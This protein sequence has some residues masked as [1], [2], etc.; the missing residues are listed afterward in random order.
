MTSHKIRQVSAS[1]NSALKLAIAIAKSSRERR[2]AGMSIISGVHLVQSYRLAGGVS[3]QTLVSQDALDKPEVRDLLE[4]SAEVIVVKA[5]LF[6]ELA[7]L[8]QGG[9][10]VELISTPFYS[11]PE[12][13]N[14]DCVLLDQLQDP[15]NMGSILRS[16]AAA[17]IRQVITTPGSAFIWAP[18]VLR[19]AMGAHFALHMTEAASWDSIYNILEVPLT[20]TSLQGAK[21]LYELDLQGPRC[22]VFGNEGSGVSEQIALRATERVRIPMTDSVESMNVAASA[23]VCL[24]EQRRQRLRNSLTLE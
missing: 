2:Q 3:K 13:L 7:G 9:D 24:F 14:M 11:L 19:S 15:G 17:G 23:A 16:V 18:K 1:T 12:R 4:R 22:W 21:N 5:A 10:L 6:T 8:V 20:V